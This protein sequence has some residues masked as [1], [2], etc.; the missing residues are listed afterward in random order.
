VRSAAVKRH[1][2]I[3]THPSVASTTHLSNCSIAI[4]PHPSEEAS[5]LKR[6]GTS[7][8]SAA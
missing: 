4:L 8:A 1:H 5:A 6:T 3:D 2:V 7:N